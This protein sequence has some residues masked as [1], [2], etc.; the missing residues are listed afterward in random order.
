M[1][2]NYTLYIFG[3]HFIFGLT[4]TVNYYSTPWTVGVRKEFAEERLAKVL[5]DTTIRP[6]TRS[7]GP[8][9]LINTEQEAIDIAEPILFGIYG[10][11]KILSE[12]PYGIY[13]FD[14]YWYVSGS[15]AKWY[16]FGGGFEIILD[17]RDAR[18]ISI[19]HFK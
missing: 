9:K 7:R 18:V 11:K 2:V 16:D 10:K 15:L 14:D 19:V 17:A 12:R 5:A 1:R 3:L 8:V 6:W 13:K 4:W